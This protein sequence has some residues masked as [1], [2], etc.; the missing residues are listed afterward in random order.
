MEEARRVAVKRSKRRG[1]QD[2]S[3]PPPLAC[4]VPLFG[5][6]M[7]LGRETCFAWTQPAEWP[8]HRARRGALVEPTA[9]KNERSCLR[10]IR[11][12]HRISLTLATHYQP[13]T[14]RGKGCRKN[15]GWDLAHLDAQRRPTSEKAYKCGKFHQ[16]HAH[17]LGLPMMPPYAISATAKASHYATGTLRNCRSNEV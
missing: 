17:G 3:F 14:T 5:G 10:G 6:T 12:R 13:S 2:L 16:C 8:Q 11:C 7:G 4:L 1:T 15:H 9:Q